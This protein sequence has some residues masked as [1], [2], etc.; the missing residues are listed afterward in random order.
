MPGIDGEFGL[1]VGDGFRDFRLVEVQFPQEKVRERQLRIERDGFL[2]ILF[3][4]RIELLP[5]Q[6]TGGKK[7]GCG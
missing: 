4:N 2:R 5:Q 1:E 6:D 7:I 3:G